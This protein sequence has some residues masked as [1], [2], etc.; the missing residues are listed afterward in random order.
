MEEK[1]CCF[2]GHRPQGLP[3]GENEDDPRCMALKALLA[4][5]V[6]QAWKDGFRH[7]WCGMAQGADL[8]FAE[9]VLACQAVHPE[10]ALYA[11]IP[12]PT[13]TRGWSAEQVARYHR[14]LDWIGLRRQVLV[15]PVWSRHCMTHRDRFMVERSSRILAVYDG[16][17]SGGTHYTLQYALEQGLEAIILDP[18]SLRLRRG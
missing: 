17:G 8:Y 13:Q 10:A 4:Q 14:V 2:T 6:E 11:A 15:E 12:C 16:R 9:T 7:F 5:E 3:W 18:V 1:T